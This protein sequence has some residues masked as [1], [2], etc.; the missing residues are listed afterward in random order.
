MAHRLR[1]ELGLATFYPLLTVSVDAIGQEIEANL[2]C[3]ALRTE[4]VNQ[5][6]KETACSTALR[7]RHL[8]CSVE[9]LALIICGGGNMKS[10]GT[11]WRQGRPPFVRSTQRKERTRAVQEAGRGAK[12]GSVHVL[13]FA[14]LI[15]M[16]RKVVSF[17]AMPRTVERKARC[18]SPSGIQGA[19]CAQV[20]GRRC[21]IWCP[22]AR[23]EMDWGVHLSRQL[24]GVSR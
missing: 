3:L 4:V 6:L 10:I 18:C 22:D 12:D 2:V 15:L 21:L 5:E 13:R 17:F 9:V 11:S 20:F 14:L 24:E 19:S 7:P 1:L 23:L 8:G 16:R